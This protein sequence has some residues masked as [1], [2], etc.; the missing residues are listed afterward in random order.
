MS[1]GDAPCLPG[2]LTPVT[3]VTMCHPM[4]PVTPCHPTTP[5]HLPS[6]VTY[7]PMLP[8]HFMLPCHP[9]PPV[10][11]FPA[12]NRLLITDTRCPI[13]PTRRPY[14]VVSRSVVKQSVWITKKLGLDF[15]AGLFGVR[16]L[17]RGCLLQRPVAPPL[18][19][20]APARLPYHGSQHIFLQDDA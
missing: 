17:D 20:Q 12:C 14:I 9:M 18:G 15:D 11:C 10:T 13:M 3:H 19:G 2:P 5:W 6:H 8:C 16:V 1:P 7:H 4:S